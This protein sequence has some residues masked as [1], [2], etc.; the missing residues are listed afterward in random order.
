M[1]RRAAARTFL[2]GDR[3]NRRD[4]LLGPLA[5]GGVAQPNGAL[6]QAAKSPVRTLCLAQFPAARLY[7]GSPG[8]ASSVGA[9]ADEVIE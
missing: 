2:R 9:R 4:A 5:L 6:A 3:M 7:E 1:L 8:P